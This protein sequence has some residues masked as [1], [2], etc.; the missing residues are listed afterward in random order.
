M[1]TVFLLLAEFGETDIPLQKIAPKYFGMEVKKAARMASLHQLPVPCFR[2]G[3]QKSPWL[4]SA[5]DLAAYIDKLRADAQKE[6][7]KMHS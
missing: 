4:V 6:W 7:E 2:G 5:I 3:S 1:N